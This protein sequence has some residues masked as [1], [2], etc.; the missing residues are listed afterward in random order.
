M[1]ARLPHHGQAHTMAEPYKI[2]LAA[3][4]GGAPGVGFGS[5]MG[6]PRMTARRRVLG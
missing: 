2:N 3:G 5:A 6:I 4:A 1:T